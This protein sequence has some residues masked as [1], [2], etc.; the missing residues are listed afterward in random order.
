MLELAHTLEQEGTRAQDLRPTD[1]L[2]RCLDLLI[3]LRQDS[4]RIR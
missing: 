1:V 4:L 2:L 3:R